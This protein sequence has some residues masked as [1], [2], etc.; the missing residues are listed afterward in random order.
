[1]IKSDVDDEDED[2]LQ[3]VSLLEFYSDNNPTIEDGIRQ[4]QQQHSD[5]GVLTRLRDSYMVIIQQS[6]R[7]LTRLIEEPERWWAYHKS[8]DNERVQFFYR[9]SDKAQ[10]AMVCAQIEC[11]QPKR[12][13]VMERDY[14]FN[15]RRRS[16]DTMVDNVRQWQE[17]DC[18]GM[19]VVRL[20][21]AT[22]RLPW[23]I[24][25]C[26]TNQRSVLGLEW[27]RYRDDSRTATLLFKTVPASPE[28]L[29]DGMPT[30][31][32]R[33]EPCFMGLYA[34]P[35]SVSIVVKIPTNG[36]SPLTRF[37]FKTYYANLLVE[38]VRL[39]EK[40]L[41]DWHHYYPNDGKVIR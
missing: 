17:Y 27:D 19:G 16:W 40:V 32:T 35:G 2:E 14:C 25:T 37:L 22:P 7:L 31:N 8:L 6:M 28:Y 15:E 10:Y 39:Y 20:V 38:R 1:M 30:F 13:I 29:P 36:C 21:S 12:L 41:A 23:Y 4:Q 5:E 18:R 3:E 11:D 34:T 24:P 9:E 33:M 26:V